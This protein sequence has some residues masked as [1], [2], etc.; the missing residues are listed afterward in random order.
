MNWVT[1]S[2]DGTYLMVVGMTEQSDSSNMNIYVAKIASSDGSITWSMTYSTGSNNAGAETGGF[3]SDGGFVLG[4]FVDSTLTGS[5]LA[6]KSGG[7]VDSGTPFVGKI[8]A[9]DCSGTSAP[10]DFEWTYTNT[11][12]EL[13]GSAKSLR[14]DSSDNVNF[15]NCMY[16]GC[17]VYQLSSTGSETWNTGSTFKGEGVHVQMNDLTLVSDGLVIVGQEG[18]L[19]EEYGCNRSLG[20]GCGVIKGYMIKLD[21]SGNKV[22]E[23]NQFGNY[24][25]G[26]N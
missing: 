17:T 11:D 7:Q 16:T 25:G 12:T 6:F 9:S 26:I 1:E 18:T 21:T 8:S 15:I 2:P 23:Q 19:S 5:D 10:T 3:M 22:W 24:P 4:G 14:I 20:G 13:T